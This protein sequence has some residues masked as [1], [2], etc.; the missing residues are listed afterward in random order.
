MKHSVKRDKLAN[1]RAVLSA[2]SLHP[3]RLF[4]DWMDDNAKR[5]DLE[6]LRGDLEKVG[7]DMHNVMS[8]HVE[9]TS[10]Q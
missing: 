9:Q 5:S 1:F 3:G 4:L 10:A 8:K 2:F 6:N 7:L